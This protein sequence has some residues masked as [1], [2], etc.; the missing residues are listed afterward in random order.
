MDQEERE[1]LTYLVNLYSLNMR[2]ELAENGESCPVISK[3]SNT[4]QTIRIEQVT[5][6]INDFKKRRKSPQCINLSA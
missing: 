6:N 2:L 3:T 1:Q 4:P 5:M